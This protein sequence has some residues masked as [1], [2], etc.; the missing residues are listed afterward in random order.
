MFSW[1][2]FLKE[3][4]MQAAQSA[5]A[6][7]LNQASMTMES[8]STTP[9]PNVHGVTPIDELLS[10]ERRSASAKKAEKAIAAEVTR[11]VN[12]ALKAQVQEIKEGFKPLSE[13]LK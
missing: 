11:Q 6:M 10:K 1:K 2:N 12:L 13:L 7:A 9:S 5:L 3:V 8:S 4:S